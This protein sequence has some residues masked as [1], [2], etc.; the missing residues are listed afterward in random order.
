MDQKV[1]CS[2]NIKVVSAFTLTLILPNANCVLTYQ[3]RFEGK[4]Q[5]CIDEYAAN[6]HFG[7]CSKVIWILLND[8]HCYFLSRQNWQMLLVLLSKR[9][10]FSL[11]VFLIKWKNFIERWKGCAI[12]IGTHSFD[13]TCSQDRYSSNFKTKFICYYAELSFEVY[14]SFLGQ[15]A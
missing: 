10:C 14:N 15:L 7:V 6:S 1:Q 5:S 3:I 9:S 2:I 12:K 8:S 4:Q 13:L 11:L